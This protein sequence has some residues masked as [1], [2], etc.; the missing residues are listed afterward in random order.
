LKRDTE[1]VEIRKTPVD[2][3]R[4]KP[5]SAWTKA[6]GRGAVAMLIR[7]QKSIPSP[8]AIAAITSI[9][10]VDCSAQLSSAEKPFCNVPL[11]YLLD[12]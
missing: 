6:A 2:D 11:G 10:T 1:G 3:V 8:F 5:N 9:I 12:S 7:Q 4:S